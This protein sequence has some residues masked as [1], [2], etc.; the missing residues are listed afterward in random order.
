MGYG[1]TLCFSSSVGF[2]VTNHS[3]QDRSR[4]PVCPL[5]TCADR[6][7]RSRRAGRSSSSVYASM[8]GSARWSP[9]LNRAL[10]V[11]RT[12]VLSDQES[13]ISLRH[14]FQHPRLESTEK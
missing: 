8:R 10:R 9:C 11:P 12:R 3:V 7:V 14:S 1:F 6:P 5:P 13:A 2:F 4:T